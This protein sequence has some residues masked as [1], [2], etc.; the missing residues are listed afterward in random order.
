MLTQPRRTKYKKLFKGKIYGIEHKANRL[1]YGTYGLKSLEIGRI[2]SKQIEAVRR[3]ISRKLKRLGKIHI[4]IFPNTPVT[5]KPI[6]IRM[7]KGKGSVDFW[8]AKVKPGQV[9]FEIQGIK[10]NLCLSALKS[11]A[12]KLSVLTLVVKAR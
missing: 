4:R 5:K 12:H 7:G 10:D 6:E 2:N 3:V 11:A 8:V 1:I 9:L